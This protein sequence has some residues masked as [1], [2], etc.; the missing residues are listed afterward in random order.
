[1]TDTNRTR[2]LNK[3]RNARNR[4]A[5][6][7]VFGDPFFDPSFQ[8]QYQGLQSSAASLR[9][10]ALEPLTGGSVNPSKPNLIDYFCDVENI[11]TIALTNSHQTEAEREKALADFTETYIHETTTTAYTPEQRSNLELRIGSLLLAYGISPITRYFRTVRK[12]K[13][14]F[15][16]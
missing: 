12:S 5:F 6:E 9:G 15:N 2:V 7:E 8:G 11:T 1:M 4:R 10:T 3:E 14:P 13:S 16:L